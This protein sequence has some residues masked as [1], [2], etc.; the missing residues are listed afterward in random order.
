[1]DY[2]LFV[3][4]TLRRGSDNDFA[5][6][7]H[8]TSDFV[9]T[10]HLRGSLYRIAHYPGWVEDSGGWVTGEIWQPR[11]AGSMLRELDDY[12]GSDYERVLRMVDT[13]TGPKECWV[14]LFLAST[15]KKARLFT[16]DW[17]E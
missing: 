17:F 7:L 8:E 4:G 9:S 2:P 3:Y 10:G 12:E 16:G 6:L 13:P 5:R 1:M 14:Y 15:E 11:D